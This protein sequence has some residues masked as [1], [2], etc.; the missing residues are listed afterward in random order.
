M[1]EPIEVT[2]TRFHIKFHNMMEAQMPRPGGIHI[3]STG[4]MLRNFHS[5]YINGRWLVE[6]SRGVSYSSYAMGYDDNLNPRHPRGPL[7][8]INFKTLKN[9]TLQTAR[10][11][12][13]PTGGKV[14]DTIWK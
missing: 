8:R 1:E 9:V 14:I 11:I 4:N 2:V 12:A 5:T 3:Y 7:E 10:N 13:I 6:L